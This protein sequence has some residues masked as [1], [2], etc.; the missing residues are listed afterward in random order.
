MV[1][2]ISSALTRVDFNRSPFTLVVSWAVAPEGT[3][4]LCDKGN[5][6]HASIRPSPLWLGLTGL[7]P[8]V[9]GIKPGHRGIKPG[10]RGLKPGHRGLIVPSLDKESKKIISARIFS[11][12]VVCVAMG[13]SNYVS[14]LQLSSSNSLGDMHIFVTEIDD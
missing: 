5:F 10:H 14:K 8:G 3:L 4:V 2:C 13:N 1:F 12:L 11:K 7:E 6:V 9:R